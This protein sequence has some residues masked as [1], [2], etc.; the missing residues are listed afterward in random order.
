[1]WLLVVSASVSSS[2]RYLQETDQLEEWWVG[3]EGSWRRWRRRRRRRR[4]E[5]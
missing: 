5:G 3:D 4:R 2:L 1:M